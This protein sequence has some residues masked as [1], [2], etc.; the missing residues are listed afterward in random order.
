MINLIIISTIILSILGLFLSIQTIIETRKKYYEEYIER[1]KKL[2][3]EENKA[4]SYF[5]K[6]ESNNKIEN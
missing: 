5:T 6:N 4:N 1:K 3:K 2:K